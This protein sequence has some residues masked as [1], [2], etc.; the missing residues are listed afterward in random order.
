[1]QDV[2]S[3]WVGNA[4]DIPLIVV[5]AIDEFGHVWEGTQHL[6]NPRFPGARVHAWSLGPGSCANNAEF[7]QGGT[8]V[9]TASVAGLVSLFPRSSKTLPS[10]RKQKKARSTFC[11]SGSGISGGALIF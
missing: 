4:A 8:S 6:A 7:F 11:S 9:A 2:P 1:M 10:Y 5:G 3:V